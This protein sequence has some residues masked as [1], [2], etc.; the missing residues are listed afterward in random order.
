MTFKIKAT[1]LLQTSIIPL[2]GG[3]VVS[4]ALAV[5]M[6][7]KGQHQREISTICSKKEPQTEQG[8]ELR[9]ACSVLDTRRTD[10]ERVERTCGCEEE[11]AR[12]KELIRKMEK[13]IVKLGKK[14]ERRKAV[15]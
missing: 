14:I 11:K 7:I 8:R 1:R 9:T 4:S 2:M 5:P 3:I 12:Y 10:L 6:W 15:R 13:K